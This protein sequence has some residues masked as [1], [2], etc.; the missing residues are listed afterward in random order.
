M[1][2]EARKALGIPQDMMAGILNVNRAQISLMESRQGRLLPS[3][4]NRVL[5][6]IERAVLDCLKQMQA[7]QVETAPLDEALRMALEK[8]L[9]DS[10][11][12]LN[13]IHFKLPHLERKLKFYSIQLQLIQTYR[14]QMDPEKEDI[15]NAALNYSLLVAQQQVK[16]LSYQITYDLKLRKVQLEASIAFIKEQLGN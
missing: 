13:N 9:K 16:Q 6:P 8:K 5:F 10:Q 4:T 14:A 1:Q 15:L 7:T 3:K 11:L 12:T 2:L